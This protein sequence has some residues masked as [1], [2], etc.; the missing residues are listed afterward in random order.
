MDSLMRSIGRRRRVGSPAVGT[1]LIQ[2]GATMGI[3]L[4]IKALIWEDDKGTVW[5]SYNDPKYLAG[6]HGITG[7]NEALKKVETVLNSLAQTATVPRRRKPLVRSKVRFE[8]GAR[9]FHERRT[10]SPSPRQKQ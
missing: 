1:K 8:P 2:C 5:L 10:T 3:D 9:S 7:C 4:P 6:R